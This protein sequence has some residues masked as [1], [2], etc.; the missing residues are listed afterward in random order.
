MIS[1]GSLLK[2]VLV[3]M[4]VVAVVESG[5][6]EKLASCCQ[7]VS[8]QEITEPITGYMLQRAN[9]PCVRAVIFQ[10]K[11]GLFCSKFGA[12]WVRGKIE[13][14]EKAKAQASPSPVVPSSTV[15]LLSII[16]STASPPSSSSS[17]PSTSEMPADETF[18]GSGNE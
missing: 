9:A 3:V 13:A 14:F 6:G 7:T 11:S 5:P 8:G 12:P 1:C 10:T 17:L 18:S 16:T 2:S 4:V 15:S